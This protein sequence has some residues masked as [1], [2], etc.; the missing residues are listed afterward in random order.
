MDMIIGNS[1]GRGIS[2]PLPLMDSL[3]T[4][5]NIFKYLR[6]NLLKQG[7]YKFLFKS[8]LEFEKNK[9]L[10][11]AE[12]KRVPINFIS[13]G[14]SSIQTDVQGLKSSIK[15]RLFDNSL[16]I[17]LGYDNEYDNISG[18]TPEEKLKSITTTSFITSAGFGITLPEL[19]I[20]NY[21]MRIMNREGL[22]VVDGKETTSNKTVTH[23]IGPSYR[24]D[25]GNNTNV[26]LGA[27]IMLM[28]YND[29]LFDSNDPLSINAN[30]TTASYTGSLGLRFDSPLSFNMGGGLSINTPD[31][32]LIMPTQFF[33][34]SS[35]L[36]YK[37]WEKTLSTF[38]GLNIVNGK[39]DADANNDGEINN[40]KMTIKGG[41]QYKFSKSMSIGLN[42]DLISLTDK[43]TPTNDF[44]ELKGRLKFKVGF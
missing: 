28:N 44:S 5:S 34:L 3:N 24:F 31:A 33:V 29:N 20:L 38:V 27:N 1:E 15:G 2:I 30:F 13:L 18:D 10:I 43:V 9:F 6:K 11:Q 4:S 37:F 12:Y 32:S 26:S 40:R 39:K 8:P 36:S 42:V 35:K 23:T 16:S 25:T 21:S 41:A 22:G 14:N 17:N 7:T 19:P